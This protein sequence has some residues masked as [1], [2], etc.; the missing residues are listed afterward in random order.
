MSRLTDYGIVL[1][2]HMARDARRPARSARELA[3][4][5]RLP[6]P[7]VS[8]ILK[9]LA[10]GKVLET[11]RGARGGFRL[12]RPPRRVTVAEIIGAL[13]GPVTMTNCCAPEEACLREPVCIVK[14]NW[15]RINRAVFGALKGITLS[16]MAGGKKR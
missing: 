1:L 4:E 12:T 5:T 3:A 11:R 13:E 9:L 2:A 8:K 6:L 15:R 7:T 10:H 16:E 14:A